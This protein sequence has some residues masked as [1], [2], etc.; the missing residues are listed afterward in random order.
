MKDGLDSVKFQ[1]KGRKV[2][3]VGNEHIAKLITRKNPKAPGYN[4]YGWTTQDWRSIK[5]NNKGDIDY[6]EKCGA[7][8]TKTPSGSPRLCL[9]AEVVRSLMRTDSGKDVIRTQA[10]KK[11]RAEKG[12]RVPWHPRIKKIWKRVEDQT[13]KDN[14]SLTYDLMSVVSDRHLRRVNEILFPE[15]M[16]RW[17]NSSDAGKKNLISKAK[18][19]RAD[20]K[21]SYGWTGRTA[22]TAIEAMLTDYANT[23]NKNGYA[24]VYRGLIT[25]P[26]ENLSAV[27]DKYGTGRHWSSYKEGA[28]DY[29]ST[30]I[31]DTP[32]AVL[33]LVEGKV[34]INEVAP[35]EQ[36]LSARIGY[37]LEKEIKV[38]NKVEVIRYSLW[39]IDPTDRVKKPKWTTTGKDWK[40]WLRRGVKPLKVVEVNETFSAETPQSQGTWNNPNQD[41]YAIVD[42]E[43]VYLVKENAPSF[44]SARDPQKWS[45][46]YDKIIKMSGDQ[47]MELA[48]KQAAEKGLRLEL[49]VKNREY[50]ENSRQLKLPPKQQKMYKEYIESLE[51]VTI[52]L[53]R[54]NKLIDTLRFTILTQSPTELIEY[55]TNRKVWRKESN[56]KSLDQIGRVRTEWDEDGK[57]DRSFRV[58]EIPMTATLQNKNRF[59]FAVAGGGGYQMSEGQTGKGYYGIIKTYQAGFL[60]ANNMEQ[61]G[62]GVSPMRADLYQSYGW[63]TSFSYKDN[64]PYP[65]RAAEYYLDLH[66]KSKE[67]TK[68]ARY[69]NIYR[70]VYSSRSNP[71]EWRHGEFA[72]E[73]PFEE[74]FSEDE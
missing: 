51:R 41:Y 30:P 3:V 24:K 38:N 59:P 62:M 49:V 71:P 28:D 44:I 66:S 63:L 1:Y 20:M 45:D 6:S 68:D 35:P 15:K 73:D 61:Y 52:T 17:K 39:S 2:R 29:V 32:G 21:Y 26:T 8:G 34:H 36:Q 46:R 69:Y 55:L 33:V 65:S 10:R 37:P 40:P 19:F 72:E 13:P 60:E 7:E 11:A 48:E 67:A 12:E 50:K 43:P 42:G 56:N 27:W 14:P 5:V 22:K 47:L 74:Y 16:K 25:L 58:Q 57:R 23:F 54:G 64:Y 53:S 18:Q 9:P 70:P 4:S 31:H